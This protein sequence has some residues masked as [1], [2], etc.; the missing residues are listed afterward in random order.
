MRVSRADAVTTRSSPISRLSAE[1]RLV[2]TSRCRAGAIHKSEESCSVLAAGLLTV[3]KPWDR[4]SGG[5]SWR[6]RKQR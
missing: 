3:P 6:C 4:P 5:L 2:A 1:R